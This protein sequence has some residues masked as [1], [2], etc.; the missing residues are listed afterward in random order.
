MKRYTKFSTALLVLGGLLAI[1]PPVSLAASSTESA[2][3]SQ[4]QQMDGLTTSRSY[5]PALDPRS[6][7][8]E[9]AS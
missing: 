9:C 2:L 4:T 1:A 5:N 3:S 8:R 6:K 7:L